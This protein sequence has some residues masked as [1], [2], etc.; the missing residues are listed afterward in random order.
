MRLSRQVS[1]NVA[2]NFGPGPLTFNTHPRRNNIFIGGESCEE[3]V[4]GS[5]FQGKTKMFGKLR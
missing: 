5:F 4:A 3:Y 1:L 2:T